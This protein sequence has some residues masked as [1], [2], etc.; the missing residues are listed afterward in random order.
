MN[1][2]STLSLVAAVLATTPGLAVKV[3]YFDSKNCVD[4][5]GLEKCYER[6]DE[7]GSDCVNKNCKEQNIDYINVCDC[8]QLQDQSDYAG[9]HCWNQLLG[10]MPK[11]DASL[12]GVDDIYASLIENDDNWPYCAEYMDAFP[13]DNKLDFTPHSGTKSAT[14]Y[15]PGGLPRNG[16]ETTSNIAGAITSPVSGKVYTW[17][18]NGV[19]RPITVA[20]VDANPTVNLSVKAS[21]GSGSDDDD[22]DDGNT[23]NDALGDDEED[24]AS[25]IVPRLLF[26]AGSLVFVA[27]ALL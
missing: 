11:T 4:P 12:R 25:I 22:D 17:T 20:K 14:F 16:T 1:R 24:T 21:D 2:L 8:V 18:Y 23:D 9:R 27:F 5:K 15:E 13:C 3:G 10:N 6:A 26:S 19:E 7:D